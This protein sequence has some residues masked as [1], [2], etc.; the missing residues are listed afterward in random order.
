MR[1]QDKRAAGIYEQPLRARRDTN[2]FSAL[3]TLLC[4]TL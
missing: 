3:R 2:Y 4:F 1:G